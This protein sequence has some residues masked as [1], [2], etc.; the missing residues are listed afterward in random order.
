MTR[1]SSKELV[2]NFGSLSDRALSEPVAITRNGRDRLVL[3][4]V[5]EYA[6]LKRRDRRVHDVADLSD[7][8]LDLVERSEMDPRHDH[9]DSLLVDWTP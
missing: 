8:A 1:V 6:R 5:E 7:A 9:L 3:L 2:R 4:S